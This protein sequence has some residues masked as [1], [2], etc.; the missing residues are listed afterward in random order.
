MKTILVPIDFSE[1]CD[2][3]LNYAVEFAKKANLRLD[4]LNVYDYP[5]VSSAPVVW[6]PTTE[7]LMAEH[8]QRLESI[9]EKIRRRHGEQLNVQ[10]YCEAGTVI[11]GINDFA[12]RNHTDLIIMGMQ[13][14]GFVSEKIIGSTVTSLMRQSVCP[15]LG[16]GKR[17]KF[18]SI[19]Q[20][21]L[22]I[23]YKDA[24]YKGILKPLRDLVKL[25]D[26]HL[27]L[28]NVMQ[29]ISA[30]EK[31]LISEGRIK[32]DLE[33]IPFTAHTVIH[34]DISVA[35]DQFV[36]D[37]AI[38]MAVIIPR[39]HSFFYSLFHEANT[40]KLAFHTSVPLLALHE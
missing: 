33:G 29:D 13:G 27:F 10:C 7:D 36:E 39:K 28:L 19:R 35:V 31:D 22:A 37:K 5:T 4:L 15:V 26:A 9:R 11:E 34:T 8:L 20:I 17:V 32:R 14:G 1:A 2:N 23:D 3:A 40:K 38:D 25:F 18:T 21:V 16:I 24:D 6:V 30:E 12:K